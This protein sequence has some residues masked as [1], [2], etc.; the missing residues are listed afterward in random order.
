MSAPRKRS[1]KPKLIWQTLPPPRDPPLGS[2]AKVF[3][4]PAS[5]PFSAALAQ[6]LLQR[7]GSGPL[8]LADA[9]IYLPTRRAARGIAEIF[10][11]QAG[12]ATLLPDF[13]PL[14]DVD[15][16]ELLL[17]PTADVLELK[18]AIKPIRRRLLVGALIRR[19]SQARG[20]V[21]TFGQAAGLAKSL[22][23]VMD[24]VERQGADLG[25]LAEL[26]PLSLAEHWA[27]V[28]EFL[29]LIH[30][31]WPDILADE[32][33]VNPAAHR[34]DALRAL[35]KQ[36]QSNPPDAPV[37]AAGSTG[38][39]PATADL[40]GVIARLPNGAVV[41]PGLDRALDEDS[42]DRL[43]SGHPQF[44]LKQLLG[45]IGVARTEVADWIAAPLSVRETLL[46]EV[47]RPAPTTDAWR[48]LAEEDTS[49]L[50]KGFEGLTLMDA[51]DPSEEASL[52]AL[53]LREALEIPERTAA[54]V[55]RDRALAR[56]VTAELGRWNI[57][58]DDSAGRPLSQTPQG[59]FLCLLAEAADNGFAPVPLLALLKHPLATMGQDVSSFRGKARELDL[60]LRG[61]RPDCGLAGVASAITHALDAA[62]DDERY[63]LFTLKTWFAEV[64]GALA[65]LEAVL[66]K[67]EI[68]IADALK[69]HIGAAERLTCN[70]DGAIALWHGTAG[71][72]ANLFVREMSDSAAEVPPIEAS[73]YAPLFRALTEE[74][75]VRPPYGRHPRLAILGP[76]EAR[77]QCFDL[78]ILGGLNEG[79]WPSSVADDPW[80]SRPMRRTIGLEQPER[81]IGLSA[82]DFAT[83]SA[84]PAVVLTRASKAEG[85]PTVASRWVQRLEQLSKGLGLSALLCPAKDYRQILT[86]LADPG[87]AE[88]IAPPSPRPPVSSRPRRLSVT[89]IEKWVRDPYA[90]YARRI[91]NLRPLDPL[92]AEIGPLERGSALHKAL[93]L[94]VRK[95]PHELPADAD[96]QLVAIADDV[97]RDIGTPKAAL[98]LWRPRFVNAAIWFVDEERKRR[99]GIAESFVEIR[100]EMIVKGPA[101]DFMLYGR[102]DRIDRFKTGGGS[103]LDYKSGAP[104]SDSQVIKHLAPQLPLEGAMLAAGGF[105]EVGPLEAVELVYVRISGGAEPGKFRPIN[106]DAG[107]IAREAAERLTLRIARFD[108]ESTG[109]DSRIAPFRADSAGDYDHLARVREWSLSGWR[110]ERE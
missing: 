36:L 44:A 35:A 99:A 16:D 95:F 31:A 91:L 98:A 108:K 34:N 50:A 105:K 7:F 84:G 76:L 106:T 2:G 53:L 82:H 25:K 28:K 45:R 62:S 14:G 69:A 41:L 43:D 8:A 81:A 17:D 86:A 48:I 92:D 89:E 101:G 15:E 52:I 60:V 100:G 64:A 65:P 21:M 85:T 32:H 47:L 11:K 70:Q 87:P 3:T 73:S 97:F 54:L 26:A 77:L 37:I 40:L 18:P 63:M 46:R 58:I 9:T 20:R 78:V 75:P 27:E 51:A 19:W 57:A 1:Q 13:R 102:A 61:P 104:P 30:T 38:S 88:R 39:I 80:F 94:F 49:Q 83:L 10:A 29:S 96:A 93:E 109:Y 68:A 4:I 56:R 90:I 103:I 72:V 67:P 55:T 24:D 6:G 23:G 66:S 110:G 79:S 71:G 5:A 22:A 74:N 12:G 107:F 33:C 42:W 59:S